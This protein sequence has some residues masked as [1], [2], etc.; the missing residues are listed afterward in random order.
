MARIH[1]LDPWM[2]SSGRE[3]SEIARLCF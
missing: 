1:Q 3:D 2:K